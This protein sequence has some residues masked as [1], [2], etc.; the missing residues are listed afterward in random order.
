MSESKLPDKKAPDFGRRTAIAKR[1]YSESTDIKNPFEQVESLIAGLVPIEYPEVAEGEDEEKEKE[2]KAISRMAFDRIIAF[3][4]IS[5]DFIAPLGEKFQDDSTWE[6]LSKKYK[7]SAKELEESYDKLIV[8][9][10][11]MEAVLRLAFPWERNTP[12]LELL[13]T[14]AIAYGLRKGEF[15]TIELYAKIS[16]RIADGKG[17]QININNQIAAIEERK[18]SLK[19]RLTLMHEKD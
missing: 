2:H 17:P 18:S 9:P 5:Q 4:G 3:L 8:D 1:L 6:F 16:K 10:V 13:F 19:S 12:Y 14:E 7:L 15:K 11:R